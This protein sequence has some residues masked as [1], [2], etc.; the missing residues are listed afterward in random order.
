MDCKKCGLTLTEVDTEVYECDNVDC[1]D[2]LVE[3]SRL[4]NPIKYVL[5]GIGILAIAGLLINN[6]EMSIV[7][8]GLS[9]VCFAIFYEGDKNDKIPL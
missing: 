4:N 6:P 9:M 7:S 2:Y 5:A 1:E 8:I 3:E